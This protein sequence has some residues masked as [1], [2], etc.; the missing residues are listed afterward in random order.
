MKRPFWL[1]SILLAVST[2]TGAADQRPNILFILVDDQSPFDLKT[3]DPAS[4]LDTPN[5]DRLAAEGIVIDRA[6]HMGSFSGAVCTPSRHMI[7]SG[8]TLWHLPIGPLAKTHCP[9]NLEKKTLAAVFGRAGYDTMRT[10][11]QGNSYEAANKEFAVRRDATKRGGDAESGS[12]WHAAQVLDYLETREETK[13]ADP[14]FIYFGFSHP[15]DTRDGTPELL[16]KYG[17]TNHADET[18]LPPARPAAPPLPLNWLPEHPFPH[19]H[20]G[21]RDEVAVS[22]V[23]KN[24]DPI[25]IRN[26][27]GR[28]YA[29]VENIDIQI[30]RVLA[31]LEAT[32]ELDNTYIFYTSDHGIAIGRHGLMG[33]QNLYEHTWRVPYLVKGPGIPPGSRAEGNIYLLDTLATVCDLAGI[34]APATNEGISFKPVLTGRK[35]IIRETLY[36]V[37]NGGTKPGMRSVRRGDWKLI[38]YETLDGAVRETQLFHLAENPREYLTQ[39]HDPA[40]ADLTG[41]APEPHQHDLAEDPA[42]AEKLVEMKALLLAEMRKH[43]DPW[44]F[45][46]QPDDGLVPPQQA[47]KKAKAKAKAKTKAQ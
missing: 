36:G 43:D 7:Q 31:K 16:A 3:Y 29:C 32:G 46:D 22:G 17:A 21:L 40:V 18:S 47:P 2:F 9:P 14:F 39:H 5:L 12:A 35:K 33:K 42:H 23:W 1:L 8:R 13:D 6:Y 20:P 11:K 25:T 44:R 45:R 15:H 24:R 30:G 4:P 28:E 38:Q 34:E 26:E 27:V 37:Y 41:V 10:C 19:G